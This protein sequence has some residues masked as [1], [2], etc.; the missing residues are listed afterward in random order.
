MLPLYDNGKGTN[1]DMRHYIKSIAPNRARLDYHVVHVHQMNI[2][3]SIFRD[4]K[5]FS[6]FASRI[7]KWPLRWSQ[8]KLKLNEPALKILKLNIKIFFH[9]IIYSVIIIDGDSWTWKYYGVS[10][11]C[12]SPF[13]SICVTCD[14]AIHYIRITD[15]NLNYGLCLGFV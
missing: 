6:D 1:Y 8:L 12:R 13:S 15:V 5:I 9:A 14:T 3:K 4:E 2:F 7:Y 10:F 11:F